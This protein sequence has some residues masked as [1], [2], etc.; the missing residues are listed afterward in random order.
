[1]EIL[2]A[3]DRENDR[4]EKFS[5]AKVI[6]IEKFQTRSQSRSQKVKQV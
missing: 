6:A 4:D 1:V 2:R 3:I 5:N